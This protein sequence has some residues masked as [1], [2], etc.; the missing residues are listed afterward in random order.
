M[1]EQA[2]GL[3]ELVGGNFTEKKKTPKPKK[4]KILDVPFKS[5]LIHYDENEKED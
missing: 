2:E 4:E 1:E 3:R 5:L